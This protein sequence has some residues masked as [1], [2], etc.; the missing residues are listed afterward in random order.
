M[1]RDLPPMP[2]SALVHRW[3][4][5]ARCRSSQWRRCAHPGTHL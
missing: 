5:D 1:G 2:D 4:Q 3:R